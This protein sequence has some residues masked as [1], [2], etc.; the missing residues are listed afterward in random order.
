MER[1]GTGNTK[2]SNMV[3]RLP[4]GHIYDVAIILGDYSLGRYIGNAIYMLMH[5]SKTG[6]TSEKIIAIL[7]VT[8]TLAFFL[9]LIINREPIKYSSKEHLKPSDEAAIFLFSIMLGLAT[10]VWVVT[11]SNIS[12]MMEKVSPFVFSIVSF[13][14]GV[15]GVGMIVGLGLVISGKNLSDLKPDKDDD[16]KTH[17]Y[18]LVFIL[19]LFG[20]LFAALGYYSASDHTA[21]NLKLV[22]PL[23]IIFI[24][25]SMTAFI[26]IR[27]T[28]SNIGTLAKNKAPLKVEFLKI[29]SA[30]LMFP[31][32]ICILSPINALVADFGISHDKYLNGY[33]EK[34]IAVSVRAVFFAIASLAIV[35]PPRKLA[36][37]AFRRRLTGWQFFSGMLIGNFTK[38]LFS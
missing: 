30:I 28:V 13:F 31:L 23:V 19:L 21:A 5:G 16:S 27:L 17:I 10:T 29:I 18:A 8:A 15:L 14:G 24:V 20:G 32:T 25:T 33:F 7:F 1:S 37:L 9:G 4:L 36:G 38:I 11:R 6:D 34:L 22:V 35:Y 12:N 3:E 2:P 26:L